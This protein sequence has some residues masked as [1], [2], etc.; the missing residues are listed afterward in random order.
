MTMKPRTLILSFLALLLAVSALAGVVREGSFNARSDG[1]NITIR[2]TSE[3]ESGL[4]KYVLERKAGVNGAFIPLVEIQ[5]KGNNESYVYVDDT[6]FHISE[7]LY[8]YRLKV[9]FVNGAAP[10]YYGPI[11]VSHRTSDVRRTWGSIKA[12]FR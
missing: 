11:T 10:M 4:L 1:N 3:D 7:S 9:V 2:W 6:A 8:Q 12:M 5:P